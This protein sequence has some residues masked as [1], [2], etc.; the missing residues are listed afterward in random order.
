MKTRTG[1]QNGHRQECDTGCE[2]GFSVSGGGWLSFK[3]GLCVAD[4]I[5]A[6]PG[7]V[8]I[9]AA[10]GIDGSALLGLSEAD[11][12]ALGVDTIG[13]RHLFSEM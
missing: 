6:G 5:K 9:F 4:E 3:S 7:V 8:D 13:V 2:V 1:R 11:L 10:R 12:Y